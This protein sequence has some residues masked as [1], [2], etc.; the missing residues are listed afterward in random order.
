MMN[1][2]FSVKLWR[3]RNLFVHIGVEKIPV[4]KNGVIKRYEFI[5]FMHFL[6]I[7][8]D[9]FIENNAKLT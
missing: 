5:Q 6:D 2:F 9:Q 3:E 8:G 4:V 7:L 1:R